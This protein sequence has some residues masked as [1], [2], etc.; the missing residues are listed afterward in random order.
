MPAPATHGAH[1]LERRIVTNRLE[2]RDRRALKKLNAALVSTPIETLRDFYRGRVARKEL[3]A[4][5]GELAA[6]TD[7]AFGG[8][9]WLAA[10]WNSL[11]RDVEL[12]QLLEAAAAKKDTAVTTCGACGQTFSGDPAAY[13]RHAC[14][15]RANGSAPAAVRDAATNEEQPV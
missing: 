9:A 8:T 4:Q 15:G 13:L 5:R 7:P 3:L 1:A 2:P 12:L 6:L 11:R 14:S 10:L